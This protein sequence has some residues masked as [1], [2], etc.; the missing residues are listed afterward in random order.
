MAK[1]KVEKLKEITRK[2]ISYC[3]I[4]EKI[5]QENSR[6]SETSCDVYVEYEVTSAQSQEGYDDNFDL[7]NWIIE[8]YP[9][10]EG[11]KVL[12]HIDY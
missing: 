7:D 4:P 6:L 9:E 11:Q 2:V 10:L 1:Q 12:I 8:N 5:A 3:D